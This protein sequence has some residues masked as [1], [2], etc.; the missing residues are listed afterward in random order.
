VLNEA[1]VSWRDPAEF[2]TAVKWL[3][4]RLGRIGRQVASQSTTRPWRSPNWP[5]GGRQCSGMSRWRAPAFWQPNF[6][7]WGA[8]KPLFV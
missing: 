8:G 3:L 2:A 4:Y 6:M 7:T 1:D 5:G